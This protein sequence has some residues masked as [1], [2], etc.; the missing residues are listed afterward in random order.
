MKVEFLELNS[1]AFLRALFR[2]KE[3]VVWHFSSPEPALVLLLAIISSLLALLPFVSLEAER[4]A[5]G[6]VLFV[7]VV[8]RLK[9][10]FLQNLFVQRKRLEVVLLL[11]CSS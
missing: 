7:R 11:I 9:R 8:R 4:L 1:L 10:L 3:L 5:L 6:L 2:F